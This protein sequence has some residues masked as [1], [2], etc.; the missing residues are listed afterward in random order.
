MKYILALVLGLLVGAGA[1]YYFFVG[2]PRVKQQQLG[3]Q[4]LQA[5]ESAGDPPGTIVLTFDEKF[6]DAL[7]GTIFRDL[8][9]PAFKLGGRGESQ[10]GAGGGRFVAAQGGG[11]TDQI[12]LLQEGSGARTTVSLKDGRID[13]PLAFSGSKTVFGNCMNFKG[14]ASANIALSFNREQQTLFGQI[15]VE[16]VNLEGVSP[17]V[18]PVVTTFVQTSINQKVNPLVIMRGSQLTLNVPV[19]ASNGTVRAQ[20][21]DVRGEIKDGALRLHIS[22][23]FAGARGVVAPQQPGT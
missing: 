2:A 7:L 22:Y 9:P 1:A 11:C 6:F 13:V 18:G 20:A 12:S 5:P 23:D 14:A 3:A 15:N 8:S 19:E 4:P 21:R 10:T 16:G 17:L